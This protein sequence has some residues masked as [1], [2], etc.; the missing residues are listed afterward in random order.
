MSDDDLFNI[1]PSRPTRAD[2]VKNREV[3]LQTARHLFDEQG[4]SNVTMTAIAEAAHVGKGTLYRH[5]NDKG[6]LCLALLDSE[7]RAIQETALE[8][9][10]SN[11]DPM[12][13]LS[14]FLE[15][16]AGFVFN[17]VDMLAVET[18]HSGIQMFTH[19]AHIWWR[20]TI[21]NFLER[22]NLSMDASYAAD[23]LF[24]MLDAETVRFQLRELEYDRERIIDGLLD[25]LTR[26]ALTP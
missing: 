5:F 17:N 20:Q 7:Q 21:I 11:H 9:F 3:I 24:I 26:L 6:D 14:W 10:R 25:T 16:I 13:N 4:A 22:M 8:R 1:I 12:E 18:P 2:A 15:R 23:V 19:P